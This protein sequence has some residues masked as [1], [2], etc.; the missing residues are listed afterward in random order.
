ML[1]LYLLR[2]ASAIGI[3]WVMAESM[4][5]FDK[6]RYASE[7]ITISLRISD[8]DRDLNFNH[9]SEFDNLWHGTKNCS[10]VFTENP[11]LNPSP[12]RELK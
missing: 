8:D 1:L 9:T 4:T 10:H 11:V 6:A 7:G 5:Y 3:G 2:W 12:T